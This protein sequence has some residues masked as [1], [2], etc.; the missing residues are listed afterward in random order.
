V[1]SA[2]GGAQGYSGDGGKATAA[3]IDPNAFNDVCGG[4]AV[5]AAGNLVLA[6][7]FNSV[8]RVAAEKTGTFY[9]VSMTAGNIRHRPAP[10]GDRRAS[11][12]TTV[13]QCAEDVQLAPQH[14][15]VLGEFFAPAGIN[16]RRVMQRRGR[17]VQRVLT[18][19]EVVPDT[20]HR[21]HRSRVVNY[22]R[23]SIP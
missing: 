18:A 8:V 6:D 22:H 12:L 17:I 23:D 14:C 7:T 20:P 11:R 5:D 2:R 9:V 21:L 19:A 4:L 1:R 3:E 15:K 16:A 13:H 10:C